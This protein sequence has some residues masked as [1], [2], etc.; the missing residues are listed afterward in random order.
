MT[1]SEYRGQS[2]VN[3]REYY[4]KDGVEKPGAKGTSLTVDQWRFLLDNLDLIDRALTTLDKTFQLVLVDSQKR[5]TVSD[6]YK[7]VDIREY[8]EKDGNALPGKKG[9]S[10]ST[11]QWHQLK[12][13]AASL[14]LAAPPVAD[15]LAAKR[16]RVEADDKGKATAQRPD[17]WVD[18]GNKKRCYVS[19]YMGNLY[20]SLREY[21]TTA[22]GEDRPGSKGISLTPAQWAVFAQHALEIEKAFDKHDK[23]FLLVLSETPSA[24]ARRQVTVSEFRGQYYL[25]IREHYKKAEEWSP[26][27]KGCS[28][29]SQGVAALLD[30][31]ERINAE[32][33]KN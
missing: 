30:N 1:L 32:V 24:S 29:G 22:T 11:D 14:V 6:V 26:G 16:P 4:E 33:K 23:K 15:A 10:L 7:T 20:V 13:H 25:N 18:L 17:F 3:I 21:Y 31:L 2:F 8:Y 28:L 5:V 19:H 27:K 12:T 9:I